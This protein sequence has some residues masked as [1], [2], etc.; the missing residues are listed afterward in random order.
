[1]QLHF[2]FGIPHIRINI[3]LYYIIHIYAC[4]YK[5]FLNEATNPQR[6]SPPSYQMVTIFT[7]TLKSFSYDTIA[8][9]KN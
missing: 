9:I 4:M 2:N 1:M 5:L 6:N 3:H 7:I 8:A